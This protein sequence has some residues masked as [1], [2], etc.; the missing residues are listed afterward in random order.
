MTEELSKL[1]L[2]EE[3]NYY[4]ALFHIFMSMLKVISSFYYLGISANIH[5]D[6]YGESSTQFYMAF[7][8]IFFLI[9]IILQF[10]RK[11]TPEGKSKPLSEISDV[12]MNYLNN[13]FI[14][15]LIPIIPFQYIGEI[16]TMDSH[17]YFLLLKVYRLKRGLECYDVGHMMNWVKRYRLKRLENIINNKP[18]WKDDQI[19]PQTN[20]NIGDCLIIKYCLEILKLIIMIFTSSYVLGCIWL[21]ICQI[22][23]RFVDKS[24]YH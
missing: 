5:F 6:W 7:F 8:E 16:D 24:Q 22:E 18:Q 15:Q 19:L 10:F 9:E 17:Y 2:F 13:N 20:H 23:E 14:H 1:L 21:I 11:V 4:Y 12:S 3:D